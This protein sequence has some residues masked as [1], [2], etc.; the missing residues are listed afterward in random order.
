[1]RYRVGSVDDGN[2]LGIAHMAEHLMFQQVLGSQT[3]FAQLEQIATYFNALTSYDATT[4]ITRAPRAYLDRLLA[5]EG[6]RLALRCTSISDSVFARE[7]EVVINELRQRDESKQLL[8]ALQAAVYPEGHPYRDNIGGSIESLSALTREQVCAFVDQH[9]VPSNAVLVVS[10]NVAPEE[11]EASLGKLLARAA[12]RAAAAPAAVPPL[13]STSEH[14]EV[15]APIDDD[16]LLVAW[17]LPTDPRAR[18]QLRAIGPALVSLIAQRIT[19]DVVPIELGD[20]RAPSF[21]IV[22][23]GDATTTEESVQTA[24]DRAIESLPNV[25]LKSRIEELDELAFNR[26]Q[27]SAIYDLYSSLEES[28]RRDIQLA[29]YVLEGRDPKVAIGQEFEGVRSLTSD[30]AME[31]ARRYFDRSHAAFV[32]LKASGK[33]RGHEV[34]VRPPVHDMG[35]RRSTP[36][37]ADAHREAP[38]ER[39]PAPAITT[40]ELANGMHVVLMETSTVPTVDIRLVF[41]TGTADEARDKRGVALIAAHALDWNWTYLNDLLAFVAAGGVNDVDVDP[42]HTRF[43][44]R[45]VDMH[46]DYLLAG[47]RRWVRDGTYDRGVGPY[48]H[49]LRRAAH[50]DHN[51]PVNQAWTVALFGANHPYT[52]ADPSDKIVDADVDAFR[53]EHYTPDNATLVISGHFD[54]SVANQWIDYLFDDWSGHMT[55]RAATNVATPNNAASFALVDDIGQ[56]QLNLA[57]PITAHSRAQEL[58]AAAMLDEI[59][60]DV[61]HQ[62]GAS[63]GVNASL[64]ESRLAAHYELQGWIDISRAPEAMHL[65]TDRLAELRTDPDA[66][67]RAFITARNR[68]LVQL[69]PST[70][71]ALAAEVEREVALARPPLTDVATAD[72]VRKLTVDAMAPALADLDM[73]HATVFVRGPE[74]VIQ[75]AFDALGRGKPQ[76]LQRDLVGTDND[77]AEMPEGTSKPVH[78]D[79]G[80]SLTDQPVRIGGWTFMLAPGLFQGHIGGDDIKMNVSEVECCSGVG[81]IVEVG[82]HTDNKTDFGLRLGMST[83]SGKRTI[84]YQAR[85][86]DVD[87]TSYDVAAYIRTLA[88][89]RLW[90]AIFVGMHLDDLSYETFDVNRA[91]SFTKNLGIGLEGGF[92]VVKLHG[93]RI[94]VVATAMGAMPSGYAAFI[95]GLA[96]RR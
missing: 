87:I 92:D 25:F 26:V 58:V 91:T 65:L 13:R 21:A 62:L 28:S 48:V 67:A 52:L 10:G 32:T 82:R 61:R 41:G 29:T 53:R 68:V 51:R 83:Q 5:I 17:P 8:N 38:L 18:T 23:R 49:M 64:A 80:T 47:L 63:Y 42:D 36:D 16:A 14:R 45:G 50:A 60:S 88:Y 44:V 7:R 40:R 22:V 19:G 15:P 11:V 20:T 73:A 86:Y 78:I 3:L 6:V 55:P 1:M 90:G 34:A 35:M 94:G 33:R 24:L 79:F 9:Y 54:P 39:A 74:A 66:A 81:F 75:S 2:A 56:L 59:A 76:L 37:L 12:P 93:H 85:D 70:S 69:S 84:M 89:D 46:I 43:M 77:D 57:L 4:Y 96:Y 95:F 30:V 31:L 71:R 27:Q 72:E